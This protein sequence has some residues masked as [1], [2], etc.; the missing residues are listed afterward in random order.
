MAP[1]SSVA[2]NILL[3]FVIVLCVSL[4][5]SC[6]ESTSNTP[7][8]IE[9]N[10]PTPDTTPDTPTPPGGDTSTP[11]ENTPSQEITPNEGEALYGKAEFDTVLPRLSASGTDLTDANGKIVQLAGVNLGGWLVFEE[12]FCPIY[13]NRDTE[14]KAAGE[15]IYNTLLARFTEEQVDTLMKTYQ[16][17]WITTYDLDYLQSIGVN[18]VRVPFWYRNLQKDDGTWRLNQK[19]E[20]DFD[21]LDWVVDECGKR[22]I[23]V[24]LD[25]HGAPGF[26]NQAHHSGANNSMHLYDNTTA[27]EAYRKKTEELWYAIAKHFAGCGTVAAYDL[28]NEPYCDASYVDAAKINNMYDRLYDTVRA[29]DPDTIAIMEGIWRLNVLPNPA[30]MNWE[31]V[32]YEVHFYDYTESAIRANA[33]HLTTYSKQYKVPVYVGEFESGDYESLAIELYA[34][35]GASFTTWTYKGISAATQWFLRYSTDRSDANIVTDSYQTI[36]SK[37]GEVIQTNYAKSGWFNNKK[38]FT[39]NST[40]L[41]PLKTAFEDIKTKTDE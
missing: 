29:A 17:N 37:W 14:P 27:G 40:L 20:I 6:A 30:T 10:T 36:L 18:C 34:S 1:Q 12:W 38:A 23:Y 39:I 13:D 9:G 28:L 31:N 22:G 11:D 3:L 21:R 16:E 35:A 25:L 8:A 24:I 5:I 32:M 15:E 26:Q 33:N 7:P 41:T 19:G 2:R 4:L